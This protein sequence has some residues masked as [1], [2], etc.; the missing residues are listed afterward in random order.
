MLESAQSLITHVGQKLGLDQATIKQL[1]EADAEHS[2]SIALNS[3]KSFQAYRV[4]HNNKRGPYKGGVRFHP[5]VNL[6]EVRALATLM[7]LKTAAIGLPL[8]GGKGGVSVDPRQLSP[9]ELEELSRK[10]SAHLAPHIGPDQDIPAPDVNTNPQIMDWMVDA[11]Q[12]QTGDTSRASFTGKTM[13]G[14][15]SEGRDAATGYGGLI[16]LRQLLQHLGKENDALTVAVQGFGNVCSFFSVMAQRQQPNW[17]LVAASDSGA[18]LHA[19]EGLDA[20]RLETYKADRG[21]FADYQ[22]T[23]TAVISSDEL[24]ALDVDILVLAALGDAV[25]AKNMKS[26]KAP[27]IVE[28]ANAPIDEKAYQYLSDQGVIILPDI[29]ANAGGVVVSY[30]EWLQNRAGEHWSLDKVNTKLGS[31]MTAAVDDVYQVSVENKVSLK[32]AAFMIALQR[33]TE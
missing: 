8:G 26:I 20:G 12:Q 22:E 31:Y 7:S 5:E 16:A 9:D 4:Q 3:G 10:Y 19:L 18:G 23:G 14:G 1:L 17:K 15:G 28:L 2:F 32:E 25:T 33:L 13:D 29:I 6:E 21:R 30:L 27:Y 24:L 11:Y